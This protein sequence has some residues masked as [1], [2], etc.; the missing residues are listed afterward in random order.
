MITCEKPK[1]VFFNIYHI[2]IRDKDDKKIAVS[3]TILTKQ[4]GNNVS[5]GNYCYSDKDVTIGNDVIIGHNVL[6]FAQQQSETEL[7][8]PLV[9]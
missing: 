2:S 9:S 6:F 3:S 8:I 1:E 5:I 4:I 7:I